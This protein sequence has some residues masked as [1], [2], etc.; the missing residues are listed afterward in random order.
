MTKPTLAMTTGLPASGKSTVAK[1]LGMLRYNLDD[2]RAMMGY[3]RDK[4]TKTQEATVIEMML[5]GVEAAVE[6]GEDVVVDNTHLTARLPNLIRIR[7]AGRANFIVFDMLDVPVEECI[8]R[9]ALRVNSVGEAV[10]KKMAKTSSGAR[11][12]GWRLT[13]EWLSVWPEVEPWTPNKSLRRC[14]IIDLDGTLAIHAHRGPYEVEKLETDE[15]NMAVA[16]LIL[17]YQRNNIAI[18]L[19]SGRE[20][21]TDNDFDVRAATERW[22]R[23]NWISYEK[24][25]MRSAGDKRGDFIVKYELFNKF[26]R[27]NYNPVVALDDRNQVV[28]IWRQV[29]LPAW[30]VGYGNF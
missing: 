25:F 14:A 10:I 11:K 1:E 6:R 16:Q 18:V 12:N 20:E 22:L 29:G 28:R 9:D 2:M 30:Q 21:M 8:K 19:M 26:I 23:K 24:L 15:L 4:W 17:F 27:D 13:P 7:A 5:S 3:S